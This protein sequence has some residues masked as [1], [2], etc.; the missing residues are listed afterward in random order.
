AAKG[1]IVSSAFLGI[2]MKCARCHDAPAHKSKQEDL[3]QLAAM[4]KEEMIKLPETS[5]VPMDRLHQTGRAPLIEVTL[6]PGSE[7]KPAWPFPE[8]IKEERADLLAEHPE[9]P[10]DRLAAL[11]TAPEN[12]RFSRV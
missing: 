12:Q 10:R 7:V 11:I 9:D 1:M 4:M 5:S 3:F 6:A 8:F 2:E